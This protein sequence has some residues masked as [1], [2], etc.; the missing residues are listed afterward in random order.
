MFW[1][2]LLVKVLGAAAFFPYSSQ[3]QTNNGDLTCRYESSCDDNNNGIGSSSR[4]SIMFQ[5]QSR[6]REAMKYHIIA[7]EACEPLARRMEEVRM[8]CCSIMKGDSRDVLIG[9][10]PP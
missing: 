5:Q 6:K 2:M 4:N 10:R 3:G 9:R 1:L 7:A 8:T